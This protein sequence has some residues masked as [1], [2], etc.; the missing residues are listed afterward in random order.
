MSPKQRPFKAKVNP[1]AEGAARAAAAS[2]I[3]MNREQRRAFDKL[4]D[5]AADH[6]IQPPENNTVWDDLQRMS[7]R[8]HQLLSSPSALLPLL[9]NDALMAKV[10]NINHLNR[11]AAVLARDMGE[12]TN[13]FHGIQQRHA[14]KS[15]ASTTPDDHL[16]AV[17]LHNDYGVWA[18]QFEANVRPM[19][20]SVTEILAKA[21]TLLLAEKPEEVNKL[22]DE[23]TAH[24]GQHVGVTVLKEEPGMTPAQD[25]NVITDV[26]VKEVVTH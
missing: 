23:V 26:E 20:E 8:C 21:E 7:I 24:I 3:S 10:E 4:G 6:L 9:N 25:P 13:F 15:G 16:M 2:G 1:V 11:T 14:G 12:F 17:M 22:A 18:D 19:I 5:S